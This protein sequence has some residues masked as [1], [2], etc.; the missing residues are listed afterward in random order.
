MAKMLEYNLAKEGFRIVIVNN[1]ENALAAVKKERPDMIIL[2]LML[3]G[4]DGLE[5]CKA[6]R[7]QK[8]TGSIPVIMLTAKS[9][10]S[11]KIIGL[12]LGADDYMTKPFSIRELTSRIKA[13]LRRAGGKAKL[14][15]EF[16]IGPL[17]IDFSAIRV[18][19]RNKPV[20][21]TAKEFALLKTLVEAKGRVLSRGYLLDAVWG[22]DDALNVQTRTVDVHVRTLR[23]KLKSAA[24]YIT[25]VKGF[26]YR[27]ETD[28]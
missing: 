20:N 21:L 13:V 19:V 11:D 3:P 1:G 25:T 12:E 2:D 10:E 23:S 4:M 7:K 6:L 5:V 24:K 9:Q 28:E 15:D 22:L 17:T 27:F 8:E 14:P 18:S 26:G 16:S